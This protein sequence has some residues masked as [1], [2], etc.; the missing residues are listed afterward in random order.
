MKRDW[1]LI[2]KILLSVE[3][4]EDSSDPN[5][6]PHYD[7][8]NYDAKFI[9]HQIRILFDADLLTSK[10][11]PILEHRQ[12]TVYWN[13]M[14]TWNGH[15]FL[16]KIRSDDDW[17]ETKSALEERKLFPSFETINVYFEK[18]ILG[19]R[20]QGPIISEKINAVWQDISNQGDDINIES[21]GGNIS[22]AKD[23]GKAEI[24]RTGDERK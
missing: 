8:D 13:L 24:N 22:L 18:C 14:L 17:E 19:N 20:V 4:C 5:N 16:D 1:D 21:G 12:P 23:G 3:E 7:I 15:E 11:E 10:S 6:P 9:N 2:R